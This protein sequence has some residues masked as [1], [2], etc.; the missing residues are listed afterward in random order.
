[1]SDGQGGAAHIS[2]VVGHTQTGSVTVEGGADT[3]QLADLT[4]QSKQL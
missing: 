3:T 2:R 1:M 4:K